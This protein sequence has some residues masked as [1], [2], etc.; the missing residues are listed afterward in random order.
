[1]KSLKYFVAL[2]LIVNLLPVAAAEPETLTQLDF[3]EAEKGIDPYPIRWRISPEWLRIDDVQEPNGY[4]LFDRTHKTIYSITHSNQQIYVIRD[5]EVESPAAQQRSVIQQVVSEKAP[6]IAGN[7]VQIWNYQSGPQSCQTVS[8]VPNWQSA[9]TQAMLEYQQVL[10]H[11][12]IRTRDRMPEQYRTPCFESVTYFDALDPL[13]KGF[14]VQS[15][16]Y[17]GKVR[18]LLGISEVP[19]TAG[20]NEIPL[21]YQRFDSTAR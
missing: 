7:P 8:V 16:Q 2:Y 11:E 15:E 13:Q 6:K 14:P 17:N 1:M 18:H 10:T 3:I 9:A 19:A 5:S 4:I 20:W 12:Q 21:E